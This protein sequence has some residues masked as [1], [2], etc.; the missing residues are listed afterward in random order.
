MKINQIITSTYISKSMA[1]NKSKAKNEPPIAYNQA[2][3]YDTTT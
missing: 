2:Y 3:R 1:Y